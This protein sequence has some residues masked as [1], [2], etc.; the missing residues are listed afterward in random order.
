MITREQCRAARGL[1]DWCQLDLAF[2]SALGIVT[3]R[4]LEAGKSQP[5][6]AT[7]DEIRRTFENAGVDFIDADG[8]GPGVR[9]R[10]PVAIRNRK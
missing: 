2:M 8:A 7:I 4:Q 3:V 6:R 9:L 10:N 1:L 5:R